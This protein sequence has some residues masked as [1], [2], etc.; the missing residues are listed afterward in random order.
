MELGNKFPREPAA[1]KA[2]L[3]PFG[4]ACV[5]RLVLGRPARRARRRRVRGRSRPHLDLLKAMGSK[6]FIFAETSNA[7]HGDRSMPL[8]QRP[9]DDGAATGPSFGT[10]RSRRSPTGRSRR[11]CAGL[12]PPHGHGRA[13]RGRHRRADGGDRRVR[14]T[15]CSTPATPPG[16]APIRRALAATL[17]RPH[18]P[19]PRQGRAPRRH[20]ARR[21]PRT[22]ASST[23]SSAWATNSASTRCR[24]TACVD[25]RR[26]VQGAARLFRLGG[27]RG[28]AGSRRR[29]TRWPTPRW[30]SPICSAL[31]LTDGRARRRSFADVV[32][33]NWTQH[34]MPNL[35]VHPSAPDAQGRV[36]PIT[37]ASRRLDLCRLR[38]LRPE[39]RAGPDAGDRRAARSASSSSPARRG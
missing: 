8:S 31:S 18:Q 39:G 32:T 21:R 15:C 20:G 37:P 4:M 2:A 36:H 19:R 14:R 13:E 38:R 17:S 3:A 23:P 5:A 9:R 22:G 16:A 28:R 6:V 10:A 24:A 7:I 29:P 30:A 12:P 25:Y 11:A 1:L 27:R 35:L 33:S 34:A 26:G